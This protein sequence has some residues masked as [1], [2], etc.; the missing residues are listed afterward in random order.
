MIMCFWHTLV[1]KQTSK[2][3]YMLYDLALPL[4]CI[5]IEIYGHACSKMHRWIFTVE[6]FIR[7]SKLNYTQQWRIEIF[8]CNI[9]NK[10]TLP[11]FINILLKVLA[12]EIKQEKDINQV[13][14]GKK[15]LYLQ[16]MWHYMGFSGGSDGKESTCNAGDLGSIPELKKIPWRRAWQPTPAFLP[17]ESPWTE[18]PG[19]LQ[20]M[21]SQRV[22][23]DWSN[24]VHVE[25]MSTSKR[26]WDGR[27]RKNG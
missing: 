25:H 8:P 3:M 16:M 10:T 23:H 12:R 27:E 20:S 6:L 26:Y 14:I 15:H 7:N 21:G 18:E 11:A 24:W 17:G 1:N 13:Q 22:G 4:L 19:G 2:I 9:R 5:T